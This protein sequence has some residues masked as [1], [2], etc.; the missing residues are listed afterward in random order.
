M[1]DEEAGEDMQPRLARRSPFAKA[2][3]LCPRCLSPLSGVSELGVWLVP[4]DYYCPVCGYRGKV[5]VE[6]KPEDKER[7]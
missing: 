2:P 4:Q 1:Q 7:K 3:R 6:K 5:Y